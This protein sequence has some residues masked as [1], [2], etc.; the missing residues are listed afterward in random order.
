M[1]KL[2]RIIGLAPTEDP[3]YITRLRNRRL[4]VAT[5]LARFRATPA[6]KPKARKKRGATIKHLQAVMSSLGVSLEDI[7]RMKEK[8]MEAGKE[9]GVGGS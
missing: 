9:N 4:D 1:E 6:P 2:I 5:S 3:D 7:K 8:K